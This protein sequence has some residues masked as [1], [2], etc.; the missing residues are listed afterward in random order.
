[1]HKQLQ[2]MWTNAPDYREA[3]QKREQVEEIIELLD[4]DGAT[5][6]VDVG[7][8]NGA[9]A[10]S[11]AEA[12]P[13][14]EVWAF[15]MLDSAVAECRRRA[16]DRRCANLHACLASAEAIPLPDGSVDRVLM[17]NVLHHV[18]RA[19][20]AYAELG[21]LLKPGGRLVLETPSNPGGNA[22]GHLISEVFML[23]DPSHLRTFHAS[24]AVS[25]GLG[26]VGLETESVT[27][28][29]FPFRID[30]RELELIEASGAREA[31]QV[32]QTNPDEWRI[33]LAMTRIV[34]TKH[35]RR[36]H[37]RLSRRG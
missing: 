32:Q 15:D 11:C 13:K 31:L 12:F 30:A 22:L 28:S 20:Q 26:A 37:C 21:R 9:V 36:S 24:E 16:R 25:Q 29:T 3:F 34:A 23:A 35:I 17:R 33:Q 5:G 1:M 8:G 18:Q 14:C 7:C 27:H 6:L 2:D 10:V 4:L 19:E